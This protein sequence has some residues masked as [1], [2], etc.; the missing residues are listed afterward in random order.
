[1]SRV[2]YEISP[3]NTRISGINFIYTRVRDK[4]I[5]VMSSTNISVAIATS[6]TPLR[7]FAHCKL[8]QKTTLGLLFAQHHS[9][10]NNSNGI[11][12]YPELAYYYAPHGL[13]AHRK[14]IGLLRLCGRCRQPRLWQ[15]YRASRP[16]VVLL[17]PALRHFERIAH[18]LRRLYTC[19]TERRHI[20]CFA[21]FATCT[22]ERD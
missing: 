16:N 15:L 13:S 11:H 14:P 3:K 18:R 6:T 9:L 5:V 21:D 7:L 19:L 12:C 17:E 10:L 2:R 20:A 8:T 1:M 22:D 4:I